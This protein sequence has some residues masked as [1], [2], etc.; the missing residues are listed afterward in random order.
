MAAKPTPLEHMPVAGLAVAGIVKVTSLLVNHPGP[1]PITKAFGSSG[2][3]LLVFV[4]GSLW[5][6]H[7]PK[8]LVMSIALDGNKIGTCQEW[9]NVNASHEAL[10]P[11][12][13]TVHNPPAGN[14]VIELTVASGDN[15][16]VN[17]YYNVTVVEFK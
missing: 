8:L 1:L 11:V 14:H 9:S 6:S 2:G 16:D 3:N 5:T 7:Q 13:L 4:S 17:D 12:L 15:S 10:V